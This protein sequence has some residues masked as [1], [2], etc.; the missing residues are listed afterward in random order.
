MFIEPAIAKH[1]I[2]NNNEYGSARFSTE[3]EIN[4]YFTKERI[5]GDYTSL[6]GFKIKA[7]YLGCKILSSD[8][9]DVIKAIKGKNI[10]LYQIE[11]DRNDI[12]QLVETPILI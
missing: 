7:I 12:T 5:N 11:F 1:K 2:K 9:N 10:K 3:A 6:N 8:K 4:K